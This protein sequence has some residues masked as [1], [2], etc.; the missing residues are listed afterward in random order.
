MTIDTVRERLLEA[1]HKW[2]IDLYEQNLAWNSS[3]MLALLVEVNGDVT[4]LIDLRNK[5]RPM[6]SHW[7]KDRGVEFLAYVRARKEGTV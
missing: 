2:L 6:Q 5:W 4:A 1:D 7:G 3:T